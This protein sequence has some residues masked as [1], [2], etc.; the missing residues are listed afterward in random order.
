MLESISL[1]AS[2]AVCLEALRSGTERK[3][4][5]AARAGLNLKQANQALERLASLDL[6]A[7]NH[8]RTWHPTPR[9]KAVQISIAPMV[10]GRGRPQS[11]GG[12]PGG[13]GVRLLGLLDRPRRGSELAALLGVTRQRIHQ[14][15]IALFAR[16]LIRLADPNFP[17]F[18]IARK[19]DPST[20]LEQDQ[21][22]VL[23]AFPE[24]KAT[25][26]SKI[27]LLT[28]RTS[29]RIVA[30]TESLCAAGLIEQAGTTS[31][32]DLYRL[33]VAGSAH[34]QRSV[35]ARHADT[36]PLPFRSDRVF[37][38]LSHLGNQGP[39]RTRDIG[40]A[41]DVSQS[42]INALMQY[43]KRKNMVRTQTDARFAPYELTQDG[44]EMLAARQT[45]TNH[46]LQSAA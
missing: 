45:D 37:G 19:D 11:T 5:I 35:T 26:L 46:R 28:Q 9:G 23:S 30:I 34:W 22:R 3:M 21:E 10:R 13:S 2:E 38:V 4:L 6:A 20:L 44:R 41:L 43:L 42:S 29:G 39:T 24:T 12:I 8:C 31:H 14:V 40:L 7:T 17:T 25:T 15:V 1:S 16:G 32:G 27:L 18:V 36:P 33:T